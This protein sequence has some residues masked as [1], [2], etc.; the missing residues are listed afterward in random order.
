MIVATVA[1]CDE[2]F[3]VICRYVGYK[4]CNLDVSRSHS[5]FAEANIP[6]IRVIKSS[7]DR[8]LWN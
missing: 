4:S 3:F 1:L 2:K 5:Y 6:E 8:W 7:N